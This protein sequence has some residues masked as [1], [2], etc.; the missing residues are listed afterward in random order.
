MA[1]P[2]FHDF[3]EI[4]RRRYEY[5]L[6]VDTCDWVLYRS[7]FADEIEMD[8]SDFSGAPAAKMPADSWIEA[9]KPAFT[10]LDAT[11][12]TMT[13]PIV[14]VE[15][16]RATCKMYMQAVHFLKND[17]GDRTF[18]M[19]GYYIDKLIKQ[20][21]RWLIQAVK[22]SVFWNTGN[23]HIMALATEIGTQKLSAKT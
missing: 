15:G 3:N 21:D 17:Q 9:V 13:N 19:G 20:D 12:H 11:Q 10:G 23:R 2:S 18:T 8:F 5:A 6:G 22:L 14:D 7:I 16:D 1:A 4:T